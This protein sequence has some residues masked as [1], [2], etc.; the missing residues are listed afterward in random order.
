MEKIKYPYMKTMVYCEC[1]RS[2]IAAR[3]QA[4]LASRHHTDIT[5]IL[6]EYNLPAKPQSNKNS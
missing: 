3:R 5:W 6:R 1:G 4:H 2:F